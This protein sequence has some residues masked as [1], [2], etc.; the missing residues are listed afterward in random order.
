VVA[1]EDRFTDGLEADAALGQA[2]DRQR[3][4]DRAGRHH[5]QVVAQV[6]GL[7]LAGLNR[8]RPV[9]M[10]DGRHGPGDHLALLQHPAQR[11]H[12]VPGLHAAGCRLR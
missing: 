3:P 2:G 1:Q 4:G 5:Q 12:H 9:L 11:H 10:V 7:A 8:H 6:I